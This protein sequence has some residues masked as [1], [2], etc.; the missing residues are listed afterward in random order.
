MTQ[1][2]GKDV[3]P[4]AEDIARELRQ[5]ALVDRVLGLEA[6]VARLSSTTAAPTGARDEV[7]GLR[8]ELRAVYSSRTWR[9]G[10]AVLKPARALRS[11]GRK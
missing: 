7:E 6:E 8:A 3:T 4:T 9:I 5:L 2:S 11:A 1:D 10:T